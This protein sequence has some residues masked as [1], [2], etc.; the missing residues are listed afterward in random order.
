M[1]TEIRNSLRAAKRDY[2]CH[3]L[4]R[5]SKEIIKRLKSTPTFGIQRKT[6]SQQNLRHGK[7]RQRVSLR[8]S[9]FIKLKLSQKHIQTVVWDNFKRLHKVQDALFVFKSVKTETYSSNQKVTIYQKPMVQAASISKFEPKQHN[10]QIMITF[11]T[12][13]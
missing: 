9:N 11:S 10:L 6:I 5:G 1:K 12:R 4:W 7:K 3:S 13:N 8:N 2:V